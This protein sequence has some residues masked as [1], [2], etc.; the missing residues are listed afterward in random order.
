MMRPQYLEIVQCIISCRKDSKA[1]IY[2][3]SIIGIVN[4]SFKQCLCTRVSNTNIVNFF[5]ILI[6][7]GLKLVELIAGVQLT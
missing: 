2:K 1:L 4:Q 6:R 3:S 5:K 7:V